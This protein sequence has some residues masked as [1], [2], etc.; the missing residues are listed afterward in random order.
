MNKIVIYGPGCAKC[1]TLAEITQ[2]AMKELGIKAPLEKVT[3][4]MQFAVA[5][6]LMTPA[7]KVNEKLLISGKVPSK[8]EV[9]RILQEALQVEAGEEKSCCRGSKEAASSLRDNTPTSESASEAASCGC[10]GGACC[11]GTKGGAG[12]KKTVV[13]VVVILI[14]L[15]VVKKINHREV[16][17]EGT[18]TVSSMEIS[19]LKEGVE[20]TYF[21][22]G[23]RCPTCIRMEKWAKAAIEEGFRSALDEKKLVFRTIPADEAI[24]K[25]YELTTK[26]LIISEWK[27]GKEVQWKNLDE[28]WDLS[29][30][31]AAFKKYVTE[32]VRAQLGAL[33]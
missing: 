21:E 7:L 12:W 1:S 31:E 10:G 3:D 17:P 29:G 4:V 8:E 15:A 26:S 33:K 20:V 13:I 14:L 23:A 32:N 24:V 27:G 25:K 18:S 11:E 30:D 16:V 22:Y 9:K 19:P 6:V 2:Q 5:G 28:I